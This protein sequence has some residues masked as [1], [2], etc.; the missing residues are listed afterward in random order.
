[1]VYY[2]T[3]DGRADYGFS[4]EGQRDGTWRVYIQSQPHYGGRAT[5]AHSTHRFSD[6]SRQ[7][8]C[9]DRPIRSYEDAKEIAA[10]WADK[11]QEYIRS[12]RRF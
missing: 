11:T 9:W 12:G 7:Y 2:R 5:D 8:I 4:F 6:G 3:R 10:L 1:M